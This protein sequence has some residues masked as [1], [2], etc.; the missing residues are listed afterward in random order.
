MQVK[1]KLLSRLACIL[2]ICGI[3]Q[4][5]TNPESVQGEDASDVIAKFIIG[6][7]GDEIIV[8]VTIFGSQELFELDTGTVE[9]LLDGR[10]RKKLGNPKGKTKIG[11]S[12]SDWE[13]DRFDAPLVAVGPFRF[14][15]DCGI[16]LDLS[17]LHRGGS[18]GVGILGIDFLRDKVFRLDAEHGELKFLRAASSTV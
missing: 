8:P 11:D 12:V 9:T 7:D 13:T 14:T 4:A 6:K 18:R 16:C 10:F 15:P 3:L 17:K 1:R 2:F 5:P